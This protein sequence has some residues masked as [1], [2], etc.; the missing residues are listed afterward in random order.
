MRRSL[1][2][3]FS[4]AIVASAC[5]ALH[6]PASN[7]ASSSR[8]GSASPGASPAPGVRLSAP[9][10]NVVWA[11]VDGM[12]LYRSVDRGDHW[13]LRPTPAFPSRYLSFVDDQE[14][15]L[16]APGSPATQCQEQNAIVWHTVD[17]GASWHQT[18]ARG[19]AAA[20]CKDGI[21]FADA[22][23]GFVTASDPNHRPTVYR[24]SD[25]GATWNAAVIQDPAYFKSQPGGFTLQVVWMKQFGSTVYLE[26]YG[27]QDDPNLPR[28]NQ[29]ILRS[30]DGGAS[31]TLVTKTGSRSV[32]M[33]TESRWLDLS[34]PGRSFES[35][36]G[37]QAF[38]QFVTD[39]STDAPGATTFAFV[40]SQVGYAVGNGLLQRTLDGGTHW[41]R[42]T[43][44]G[45][46]APPPSPASQPTPVPMPSFA[47]V[48]AP[49][50]DVVWAMLAGRYI[51]GSTDQGETWTEHAVP[52]LS[53]SNGEPDIAFADGTTGWLLVNGPTTD[54][55]TQ[56]G[57]QLWRTTDGAATWTLVDSAIYGQV[58]PNG[59]GLEQCKDTFA[60][61][62]TTHG[63]IATSDTA[64]SYVWRTADGGLTWQASQLPLPP[65]YV[66]DG[67]ERIA[68]N[69]I[70]S[71]GNSVMVYAP[72][73]VFE[74][75]DGGV[76]WRYVATVPATPIAQLNFL[77]P[78]HWLMIQPGLETTDAA[79]SWHA[80]TYKDE[81][82]AGVQSVFVFVDEKVG[83]A[84][85]RGDLR[86]TTDGGATFVLI[87]N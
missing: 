79:T 37:G 36:N 65:G 70:K 61:S 75:M 13:E 3:L 73:Y 81:E 26:A 43:T 47:K 76:S 9:S 83:Y 34:A 64:S 30:V 53:F 85:V 67:T 59:L 51:F 23:H 68:A 15:W 60:I 87:K 12:H 39:F 46:A 27:T 58:S 42:L 5:A 19:L 54:R 45:I 6:P 38:G 17:A 55:C 18:P 63:F 20:Q 52:Q 74:S 14:G 31:W 28:D 33:V 62:D 78:T 32:V 82:A 40:D 4:V 24:T 77:T 69:L 57:T 49:S 84:T 50:D 29:F 16:L 11:L 48:S 72:P 7:A 80:F 10:T 44:P 21:W 8:L 71:F 66:P 41:T 22:K 25:G 1:L 56:Q 2:L 35:V 86:R